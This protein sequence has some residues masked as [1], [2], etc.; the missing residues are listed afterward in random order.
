MKRRKDPL[1][2]GQIDAIARGMI[3]STLDDEP[4]SS[5]IRK[6]LI[7]QS[8]V[9]ALSGYLERGG[10]SKD[11][12]LLSGLYRLIAEKYTPAITLFVETYVNP[13]EKNGG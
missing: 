11:V 6:L 3:A 12:E 7:D 1:N 10:F 13:R 8:R 2:G 4:I 9:D 5:A